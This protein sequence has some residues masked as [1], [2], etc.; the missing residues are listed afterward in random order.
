MADSPERMSS[1]GSDASFSTPDPKTGV[2]YQLRDINKRLVDAWRD[3][4][5]EH[6][7]VKVSHGDIFT[8]APAADAIV[9]PAN[10]F[11]FMDGG[12][13]MVY[14]MH[15]GWQMQDRLQALIREEKDGE[16]LV[17]EAVIIPVFSEET[18]ESEMARPNC[19]EGK[20]IKYLISAP[21]MRIP[22]K[23]RK[24]QML[25]WHSELSYSLFKN[26]TRGRMLNQSKLFSALV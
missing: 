2:V 9:S 25:I 4:F 17:G 7:N 26:T 14:S 19:N 13:D 1:P 3:S 22:R 23:C 12:I 18:P 24:H 15:F 20:P 10:S 11:G 6:K 5:S 8:G 21:T 16:I